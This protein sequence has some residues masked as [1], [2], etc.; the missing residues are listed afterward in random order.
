MPVNFFD[1]PTQVDPQ[2]QMAMQL[3]QRGMQAPQGQTVSGHYVAPP[4]SSYATQL[5]D[6]LAG[7]YKMNQ[8]NDGRRAQDLLN[9]GTG[10]SP[11]GSA[12]SG[13]GNW[14]AGLVGG[15]A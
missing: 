8:I 7:G 12:M 14:F 4:V 11:L 9:G 10:T 13:I 6:A 2:Q 15:G 5:A 3:M 1:P